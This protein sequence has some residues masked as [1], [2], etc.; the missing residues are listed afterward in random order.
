MMRRLCVLLLLYGCQGMAP[1]A[2]TP[3]AG[4][5]D[6]RMRYVDYHADQVYTITAFYG[7]AVTIVFDRT[8]RVEKLSAGFG[9]AWEVKNYGHYITVAPKDLLP[10]TNLVV[11][12]DRRMYLFDLRAKAPS[13]PQASMAYATDVEQIFA[14]RFRYPDD[15]RIARDLNQSR[16]DAARRLAESNAALET[17]RVAAQALIPAKPKNT[18]Y[19]YQGAESIAPF[20]AWDDGTFTYLR[21]YAE[22]D[23]PTPFLVNDDGTESTTNKHFDRDVMVIQRVAKRFVLRKGNAVVC[24]YND[25]PAG[26]T[27]QPTSGA[28]APGAERVLR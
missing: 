7:Y 8:E 17:A 6:H 16:I 10:A 18:A 11:T 3:K 9:D 28:T 25:N 2:E 26:F 23:L 4:A 12:T 14:L 20:E 24:I 15:E 22:Q 5:L 1:A 19:R 27:V 13:S 21:F